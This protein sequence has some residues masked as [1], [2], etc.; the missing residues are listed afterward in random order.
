MVELEEL[1]ASKLGTREYWDNIYK[2]EVQNFNDFGDKGEVWFGE[3]SAAKMVSWVQKN[4]VKDT[5]ILD[6]GCGNGHL[7]FDLFDF[8]FNNV[9]GI[10]YSLD[11][12]DLCLN[13]AK[14]ESRDV[15]FYAVDILDRQQISGYFGAG[16]LLDKG[17]FDAISLCAFE[18]KSPAD[19]Y[20]ESVHSILKPNGLLLLTSCN[21]TKDE[22]IK[23]FVGFDL[24][25]EIEH[26][27][28][29]FGG[30]KGKT[31]TTLIFKRK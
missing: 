11:S 8:G 23:R 7:C 4:I 31:I 12:I 9:I 6:L 19:R 13:I 2:T 10:D 22:L 28:F 29:T 17:T 1:N 26:K 27:S 14:E 15:P 21:W 30:V 5:K 24:H 3:Q 18:G 16:L 20:V 25:G